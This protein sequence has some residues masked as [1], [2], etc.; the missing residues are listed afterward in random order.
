M[1]HIFQAYVNDWAVGGTQ[2]TEL[3]SGVMSWWAS[4]T[5]D[6]GGG[7]ISEIT[8]HRAGHAANQGVIYLRTRETTSAE[9]NVLKLEMMSNKTY[10]GAS[11]VVFKF[12]KLI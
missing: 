9:G 11:N 1:G 2:Y 5:N 12:V 7:A 8:L 4:S 10:T 6:T 3:Y